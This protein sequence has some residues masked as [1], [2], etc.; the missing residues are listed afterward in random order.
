VQ[1]IEMMKTENVSL[2]FKD[3]AIRF[4][5]K[6]AANMN[7]NIENT[8]ARRLRTIVDNIMEDLNFEFE[9]YSGSTFEIDEKYVKE[10]A[11]KLNIDLDLERFVL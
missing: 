1:Y 9:R 8:G 5:A 2:V 6:T 4:I 3:D 11:E 7:K 10:K